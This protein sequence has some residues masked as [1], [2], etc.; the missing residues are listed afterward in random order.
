M[1]E[2]IFQLTGRIVPYLD[3]AFDRDIYKP[4]TFTCRSGIIF[5][6][7]EN[8]PRRLYDLGV[9][10]LKLVNEIDPTIPIR[11]YG[12]GRTP[13]ALPFVKNYGS[14]LSN[15]ELAVEYQ[16][17]LVGIAFGPTNPSGIPY[18]MMACGLPVVDVQVCGENS[19][20]YF[21][22][23]IVLCEPNPASLA[24]EIFSLYGDNNYW[25]DRS[26]AGKAFVEN[27]QFKDEVRKVLI[28]FL[29]SLQD[30]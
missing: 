29:N 18:E 3:F 27:I 16:Q 10:T 9:K 14:T 23:S 1:S 17:S 6:A 24:K 20:K 15:Q 2:K 22:D 19:N 26:S 11:F 12:G 28:D 4:S 21:D 30:S 7:K 5:Y 8:T 13:G 25:T